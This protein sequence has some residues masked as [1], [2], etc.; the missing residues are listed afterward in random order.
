MVLKYTQL[1]SKYSFSGR[2]LVRKYASTRGIIKIPAYTLHKP[3]RRKYPRRRVLISK[4]KHQYIADLIDIGKYSSSNNGMTFILTC[5][6]GF[7]KVADAVLIKSKSGLNVSTALKEIFKKRGAPKYLQT[8]QGKE[9]FNK[10]VSK[11]LKMFPKFKR[12]FHTNSELKAVIVERFNQTLMRRLARYMTH[13]KTL[14]FDKALSAIVDNYNKTWHSAIKMAPN[15]V[16][17]KNAKQVYK[18][19]YPE[20]NTTSPKPKYKLGD[21]VLIS[22]VKALF[23]KGYAQNWKDEIFI[24]KKVFNTN[25][26]TYHLKDLNNEDIYGIFYNEE[27][28]KVNHD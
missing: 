20:T 25:P 16:N 1:P 6:D 12:H 11:M 23:E 9:F 13:H 24:V 22:R 5:I 14:K 27:L 18:T 4:P 3:A 10:N 8:D 15:D 26:T 28:Q 17:S 2:H 7:T 21:R 19:L